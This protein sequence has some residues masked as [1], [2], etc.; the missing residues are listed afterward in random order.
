MASFEEELQLDLELNE[1]EVAFIREGL[2]EETSRRLTEDDLYHLIDIIGE[3]YSESGI[4]DSLEA[5][6]EGFVDI[7]YDAIAEAV[8]AIA[9][10]ELDHPFEPDDIIEVLNLDLDF[11]EQLED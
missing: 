3:Y 7:P 8:T 11:S 9:K 1:K 5:D 4:L 6:A 10:K 2:S